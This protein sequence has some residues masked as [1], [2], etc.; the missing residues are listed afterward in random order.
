MQLAIKRK[1][2]LS[3]WGMRKY[4]KVT[5]GKNIKN[6]KELNNIVWRAN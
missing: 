6:S 3:L 4:R 5:I 1:I 2:I